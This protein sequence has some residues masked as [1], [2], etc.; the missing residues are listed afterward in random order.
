MRTRTRIQDIGITSLGAIR[1][2]NVMVFSGG[3][4]ALAMDTITR[5]SPEGTAFTLPLYQ[6][7]PPAA[8]DAISEATL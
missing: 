5:L 4:K 3:G 2:D 8:A 7:F 1:E 6:P